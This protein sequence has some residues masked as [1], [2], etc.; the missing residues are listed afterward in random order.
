MTAEQMFK[1]L[2]YSLEVHDE[3]LIK[4]SKDYCGYTNFSFSL[5]KNTFYSRFQS[6]AHGITLDE[7]KAVVQQAKELGWLESEQKQETNLDYY[8]QDIAEHFI[9]DLAMVDKKIRVCWTTS[10]SDCEFSKENG[11][12]IGSSKIIGWLKQPYKK[13]TYKLTQCEYDMLDTI[14]EKEAKFSTVY[15]IGELKKKGYFENIKCNSMVLVK[16]ILAN[17]EVVG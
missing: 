15:L 17:C 4:Y 5:K 16:D 13:P 14:F 12:C 8:K 11:E 7:L 2:G 3:Q 9:D 10:C 6:V 1:E